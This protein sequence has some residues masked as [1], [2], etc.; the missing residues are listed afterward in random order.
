MGWGLR[1]KAKDLYE[2]GMSRLGILPMIPPADVALGVGQG[3]FVAVGREFLRHFIEIGQLAPSDRVLDVGCGTGRM[4][5][6]MTA[7]LN[8]SGRY[9]GFDV[10]RDSIAWCRNRITP[11]FPNFRFEWV[12]VFNKAYN[13]AGR[14][15]PSAFT[16]PYPDGE[17][18]FVFLTSVFT[19]ML[20]A[21]V[22]HF[23]DEISRVL[24]PGGRCFATFFL[25]TPATES[26]IA[27]GESSLALREEFA[28]CRVLTKDRPEDAIAYPESVIRSEIARAGL[29]IRE[30]IRYGTWSGPSSPGFTYQDVVL[31]VKESPPGSV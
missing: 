16:F 22:S 29:R 27:S 1:R 19:H 2:R 30:P 12:D 15:A 28:G 14:I 18:D 10:S 20:P 17:F 13:P 26:A 24:S 25:L 11:R 31:A 3:D 7:Y 23:L 9:R 5:V 6:P 4:A 8:P 21:D